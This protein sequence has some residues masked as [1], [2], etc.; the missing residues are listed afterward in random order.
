MLDKEGNAASV[1]TSNGSGGG[2]MIP[3]TGIMLN[4]MLG[5]EDLNPEGFHRYIPGRR[6]SS[7]I[8][9]TIVLDN[10]KPVLVTGSAGSNRIRSAI[11]QLLINTLCNGMDIA[12]A[13]EAPRLHLE[14]GVLDVEPGFSKKQM[15]WFEQRYK[16][17]EWDEKNLYFGGAN[18]VTLESGHGDSR[19]GGSCSIF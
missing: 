7:M 8:A 12:E 4:N 19:R 2:V 18:S 5:E 15:E 1:T 14:R 10:G 13:V 3:Q 16:V 9:P 6:I 17:Q 11:V